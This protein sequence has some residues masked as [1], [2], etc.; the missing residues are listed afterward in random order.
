MTAYEK[1]MQELKG[2][3]DFSRDRGSCTSELLLKNNKIMKKKIHKQI[4]LKVQELLNSKAISS[5]NKVR[6]GVT[7]RAGKGRVRRAERKG[8]Q[9]CTTSCSLR[10]NKK[11]IDASQSV[12]KTTA[13]WIWNCL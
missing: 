8:R 6:E 11:I 9:M 3:G 1:E 10:R 7:P 2:E 13:D 5:E 4:E 12:T